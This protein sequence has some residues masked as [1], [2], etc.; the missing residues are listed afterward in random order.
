[1][2]NLI[3]IFISLFIGLGLQRVKMMPKETHVSIN[4]IILHVCLPAL[5]LL[6]IPA[7]SW[8]AS[9]VSLCFVAW[10]IFG[11]AYLFFIWIGKKM[12]WSQSIIGCL[13]LTA[14][15][16]NTAFV[17]FPIIE[18]AF[19]KESIKYAVL[20]DQPG[21]FLI[22]SSL[23]IWVAN[24]FSQGR[25]PKRELLKRVVVFPPF[26]G[27]TVA[28]ILTMAGWRADGIVQVVLQR[29]AD[30]LA[31]LALISVGLQLKVREIRDDWRL[32]TWGL[33]FKLLVSPILIFGIYKLIGVP[34]EIFRVAVLEA[35]MAPMIT[36]SILA[37]S[38]GLH[39]R[40]AGLMVGVGVPFSFLTL[41]I[42]Y[43]LLS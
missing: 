19:G 14:G 38:Y 16:G 31:P 29:F 36:S 33:G 6:S 32:L 20:L 10:I 39:P 26:I 2:A 27:F 22:C 8:E 24:I 34:H 37:A 41:T 25:I 7:L 13:I 9:L 40:L 15:L 1:M 43:K 3:L 21:T 30:M 28:V 4:V 5:T 11:A 17:G 12:S 23:G 35:A 18:A 42:W